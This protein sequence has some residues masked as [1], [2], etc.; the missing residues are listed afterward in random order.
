MASADPPPDDVPSTPPNIVEEPSIPQSTRR[1]SSQHRTP[2]SRPGFVPTASDSRRALTDNPT[3][4]RT[5]PASTPDPNS[6]ADEPNEG[7]EESSEDEIE[8]E[9]QATGQIRGTKKVASKVTQVS[10]R[11][12]K[13]IEVDLAQDSDDDHSQLTT[14]KDKTKDSNGFD[15]WLLYFH[16][17]GQGP[18]QKPNSEAFACRWCPKEVMATD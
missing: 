7:P 16:P 17:P 10:K 14:K 5:R 18:N 9:P 2:M 8:T 12:G 15:H 13:G 4:A 11:T 1:E 6:L 3:R